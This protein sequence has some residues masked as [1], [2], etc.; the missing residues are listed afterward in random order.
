MSTT[1]D[2]TYSVEDDKLRLYAS[3]RLDSDIYDQVKAAGFRWAPKQDLFVAPSWSPSREDL[4]IELAGEITAEQTTMVERA[5]AKA[6]RLDDLSVK[7][8]KE[9]NSFHMA[10][11]RISERFAN[12][13]PIL[14]GHYS[15]RKARKDQ[16]RMHSAMDKSVKAA[17]AVDYW[18]YRAAGVERHANR[19][20]APGVR[21]RRIK[22]LLKSLRDCQ[23]KINHAYICVT[24][25]TKV[26]GIQDAEQFKKT[27]EHWAGARLP[28]GETA[29]YGSWSELTNGELD[30]REF[31]TDTLESW[32][33]AT[34]S[35]NTFRWINHL[36][37]R[38]GYERSELGDVPRYSGELTATILQAF[39]RE[40]GSHKPKACLNGDGSWSLVSTVPMP[41]HVADGCSIE[42]NDD[43]WRDL[44]Q[45]CGHAVPEKKQ[46]KRS[47]R[48]SVPLINPSVEE[49][50]R[51]Q[52]LWNSTAISK[53]SS[54]YPGGTFKVSGIR[55]T[56]QAQYS[57]NSKGSYSPYETIELDQYGDKVWSSYKGKNADPVC[58]IRVFSSGNSSLYAPNSIVVIEDKPVK[59]LPIEWSGKTAGSEQ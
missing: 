26:D 3:S 30:H 56:T 10:A 28:T 38:L 50:E 29:R 12:G 19:K 23:R 59:A 39:A 58:R 25:W 45:S 15:E 53:H 1:L 41:A 16:A 46:R 18:A 42:N 54:K 47:T 17:N 32:V 40:Q 6:Q 49:A 7:R 48:V 52:K 5:E 31:V 37:N 43:G 20:A 44:M 55:S 24:L 36:L 34:Q 27:A 2:A 11:Q 35:A 22:T 57:A 33:Q 21:A 8:Q 14:I 4:C 13:Q 51:L 9:S